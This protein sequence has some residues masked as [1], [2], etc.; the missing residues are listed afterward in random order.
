MIRG[1]NVKGYPIYKNERTTSS[2]SKSLGTFPMK[3]LRLLFKLNLFRE[4]NAYEYDLLK[5]CEFNNKLK[6]YTDLSYDERL[7]T[8]EMKITDFKQNDRQIYY[9]NVYVQEK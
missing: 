3:I 2:G 9:A 6:D 4:I 1:I 8:R 7:C 5:T